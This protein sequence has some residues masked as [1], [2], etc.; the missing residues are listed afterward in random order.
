MEREVGGGSEEREREMDEPNYPP[1]FLHGA[2]PQSKQ[3]AEKRRKI[4]EMCR[5]MEGDN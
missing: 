5:M 1:I 2:E 4:I 3:R